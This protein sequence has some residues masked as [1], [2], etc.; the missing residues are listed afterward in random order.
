[1]EITYFGHS[2]FKIKTKS[3][4]L[5]TDPF[6]P[7]MVGLKYPLVEAEIVTISHDHADHNYLERI[8]EI[9]KVITGPG[10]YEI[11]EVS[12][13]GLPSWHD[14]QKGET[15]GK[16]TIYV[17]EAE[18]LRVAHLGDLGHP[19]SEKILEEIGE[20]NILMVPVG[21]FY[22]VGPREALE[23]ISEIEPQIIIPM[24]FQVPGLN[25]ETFAKLLPLENF[26]KESGL[27][28]EKMSKLQVKLSDIGEEQKII[29]L[30]TK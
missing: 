10:E 24:H 7:K 19:L 17:F 21:G 29:E 23:I 20:I 6:D 8:K 22:T 28:V 3:I 18:D 16:N 4:N 9:K 25:S 30:E 11:S 5:V 13:I 1:M 12:I 26:L 15:R 2:S 14:D 27:A